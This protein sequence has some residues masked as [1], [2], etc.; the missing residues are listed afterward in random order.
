M[1]KIIHDV[2]AADLKVG[3]VVLWSG[4]LHV[5]AEPF[6]N[7]NTGSD[8]GN[9]TLRE[10]QTGGYRWEQSCQWHNEFTIVRQD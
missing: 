8:Y 6:L 10:Q 5:V 7:A 1:L 2:P 4:E 3:D 9:V